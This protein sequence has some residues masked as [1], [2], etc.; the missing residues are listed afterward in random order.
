MDGDLKYRKR[1]ST[2]ID[3]GLYKAFY[4]HSFDSR[5]P[6]SRL[7]D[8]AIEGYLKKNGIEYTTEAPYG[9]GRID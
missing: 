9:K 1:I 3:K 5:I 2:T 4:N 8:D 7:L 6:L